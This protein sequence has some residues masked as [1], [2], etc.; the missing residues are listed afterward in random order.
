MVCPTG[1]GVWD[2]GGA[3]KRC[4]FFSSSRNATDEGC[5]ERVAS[6]RGREFGTFDRWLPHNRRNHNFAGFDQGRI[7][8][9]QGFLVFALGARPEEVTFMGFLVIAS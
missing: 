8:L 7:P 1:V 6:L 9:S 3:S 2:R 4:F 5:Y